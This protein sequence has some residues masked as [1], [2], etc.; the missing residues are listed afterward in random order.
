[1]LMWHLPWIVDVKEGLEIVHGQLVGVGPLG[2]S[3]D[4]ISQV[5][6]FL[7]E[8]LNARFHGLLAQESGVGNKIVHKKKNFPR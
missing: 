3:Q 2:T 1:M 7:L 8:V 4:A 5:Q 6:L